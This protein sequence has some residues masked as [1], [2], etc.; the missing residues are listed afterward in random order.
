MLKYKMA[1]DPS[2]QELGIKN[3]FQLQGGIDKYFKEFPDGGYWKGVNYVFDKRFAHAPVEKEV[4][5][6]KGATGAT[7]AEPDADD[8]GSN[9]KPAAKS[10]D[11]VVPM[12]KCEACSKPWDKYRGKRR[13]PTCGV[14]SLICRDC[15]QA[16]QNG[17]K[18]LDKWIRCDL[19]VEQDIQSKKKLREK[20]LRELEEYESR[21]QEKG[22]LCP[23]QL[24]QSTTTSST[25]AA[26]NPNNVT[27]LCLKNMCRQHMTQEILMDHLPGITHIVWRTDRGSNK[28][29][30]QGWVEMESPE[31][32]AAAVTK[33]GQKALGRPLYV[34]YQPPDGKDLWP[35]PRSAVR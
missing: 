35:P 24:E 8:D 3:V 12:G 29:L 14:P 19:C 22:L 17:T 13:C 33:S 26:P 15:W 30:G 32:A 34:E 11:A 28:F 23:P 6:I 2:V 7:H 18:K 21:L 31:A 1:N 27:R 20:E 4:H 5:K 10:A 9:Q 16:D 25:D